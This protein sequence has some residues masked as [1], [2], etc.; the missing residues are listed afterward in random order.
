VAYELNKDKSK[1]RSSFAHSIAHSIAHSVANSIAI[2]Y[3][4]AAASGRVHEQD[5]KVRAHPKGHQ[6]GGRAHRVPAAP[7]PVDPLQHQ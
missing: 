3:I 5:A 6:R 2:C 4:G 7:F 1:D